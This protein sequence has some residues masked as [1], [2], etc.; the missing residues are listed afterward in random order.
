MDKFKNISTNSKKPAI[1]I[2]HGAWH[3]PAHYEPMA[4]PLREAGFSVIIPQHQSVGA[5]KDTGN[6]LQNDAATLARLIEHQ[7]RLGKDMILLMHS[8][9]GIAG[10]EAVGILQEA[11]SP[12]FH[13]LKRLVY[14]A[15]HVIEKDSS[16][17]GNRKIPNIDTSE[18]IYYFCRLLNED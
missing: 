18:V 14:L 13:R 3:V 7:A 4:K 5:K 10:S 15:A 6:A 8:Y 17:F 12:G 9:G 1:V 11:R 16:F 2:A